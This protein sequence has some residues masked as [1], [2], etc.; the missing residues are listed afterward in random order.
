MDE[1]YCVSELEAFIGFMILKGM[2]QL[3]AMADY[4]SKDNAFRYGVVADKISRDRFLEIHRY[5]HFADNTTLAPP[6]SQ[7]Y[8]KLGKIQHV[9]DTLNDSYKAVYNL[10]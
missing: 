4:W 8:N 9:I 10:H 5:L 2:V 1:G 7:E 6:G 3:P